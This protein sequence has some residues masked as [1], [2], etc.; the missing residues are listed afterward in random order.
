M[1][2]TVHPKYNKNKANIKQ[3]IN[4]LPNNN[5]FIVKQGRNSILWDIL[6][7]EKVVIK[8]FKKLSFLKS[9]IYT[10]FRTNKAKRSFDY[11]N[12]LLENNIKT[13]F[14]IAYI[15]QKNKLGLLSKC[16]YISEKIEYDF[17]FRELI[18]NPLFPDYEA[19]L[20]GFT[21]FTYN[22]HQ[23]KILFLDHSPG[24]TLIL[25]N[26]T[27]YSFYLIDLNRMIFKNLS[28]TERMQ[29]FRK[30]WLSK[31]MIAIVAKEYALLSNGNYNQFK[32]ILLTSSQNFKRKY[33]R[34]KY[35]KRK[36]LFKK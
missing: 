30:L 16:Y 33:Y 5:N 22:M 23:A 11:A 35:I 27:S 12:Y 3:L 21:R 31:R 2:I 4:H 8:N 24:N 25:K 14:P 34:K 18:H 17:T 36:F 6:N 1:Q 9:I 28:L 19:I 26:G 10:F 15:E 29:N 20:K 13:P 7:E 32:E